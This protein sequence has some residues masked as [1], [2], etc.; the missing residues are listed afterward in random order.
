MITPIR[1]LLQTT[2]PESKDDWSLD[3]FSLL[4]GYLASL[5]DGNDNLLAEVTARNRESEIGQPGFGMLDVELLEQL[6]SNV[7]DGDAMPLTS[8]IHRNL[9]LMTNHDC[10]SECQRDKS[11]A[12][13]RLL[14]E[15][16][17][18]APSRQA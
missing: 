11:S 7:S 3:R 18:R 16:H 2:I 15:P 1:V 5:T 9:K 17:L 13:S 8:N 14:S 12:T 6:T 10:A 4:R